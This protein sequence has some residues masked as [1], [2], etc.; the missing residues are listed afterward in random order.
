MEYREILEK[1][2]YLELDESSIDLS[3]L[4]EN[5]IDKLLEE[6]YINI[7]LLRYPETN[8]PL[9]KLIKTNLKFEGASL[10]IQ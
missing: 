4:T 8:H 10:L 1:I 7:R 2:A 5:F 3:F 6:D 9:T